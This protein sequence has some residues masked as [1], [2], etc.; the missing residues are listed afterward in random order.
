MSPWL[1]SFYAEYIRKN[2]GSHESQAGIK[3]ARRNI[4]NHRYT[5]DTTL[6]AESEEELKGP[7]MRV[8]EEREKAGLKF[9]IQKTKILASSPIT[10]WQIEGDKVEAVTHFIFLG[11]L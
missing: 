4:N 9:N 8:K 7:L 11:S 6:M 1:F 2:A 5:D 3:N 10:S